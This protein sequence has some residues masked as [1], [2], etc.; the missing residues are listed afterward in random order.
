MYHSVSYKRTTKTNNFT[1]THKDGLGIL[2]SFVSVA[3]VVLV[4][5]LRTVSMTLVTIY[6]IDRVLSVYKYLHGFQL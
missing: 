3:N 2:Q 1:I 5:I 4:T 6:N